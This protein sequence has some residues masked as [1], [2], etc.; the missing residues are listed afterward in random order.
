[1]LAILGFATIA[2]L[3]TLILGKRMTPLSALIAVPVAAALAGGFGL[4]TAGFM[5]KRI[6]GVAGVAGMF[7]FAILYFGI[8][9]DAGM[10]DPII[11]GSLRAVGF[12]PVRIVLGTSLLALLVH[13]DGSGAVTF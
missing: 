7:V 9:T 2:V 6:Q 4:A 5:V 12:N 1:M 11:D 10:L 8:M 3:L 13:L